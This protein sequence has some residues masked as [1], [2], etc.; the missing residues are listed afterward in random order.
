MS[1]LA[2]SPAELLSKLACIIDS[3]PHKHGHFVPN[4]TIPV[5]APERAH[6]LRPDVIFILALSYREEIAAAV[7][8]RLPSCRS[9]LTLDDHGKVTEL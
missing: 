8:Q 2:A 3:D 9:I 5:V 1:I 6:E 7:R 4:S